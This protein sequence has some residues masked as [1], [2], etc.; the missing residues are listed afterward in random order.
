M[1]QMF[2]GFNNKE[3]SLSTM[4]LDLLLSQKLEIKF[5][6]FTGLNG[7]IFIFKDH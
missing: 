2:N 3:L 5:L 4:F 7:K 1:F 6:F